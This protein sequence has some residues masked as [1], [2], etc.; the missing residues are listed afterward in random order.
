MTDIRTIAEAISTITAA[1]VDF[2]KAVQLL[3]KFEPHP[4]EA[5]EISY[6]TLAPDVDALGWRIVVLQRGWV[7]VGNVLRIG[8]DIEIRSARVIRRWGTTSGLGELR[9][10]PLEGTTLDEAGTVYAH[11]LGVVLMLDVKAEKWAR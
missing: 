11:E 10:G 6:S 8:S 4:Y 3:E 9:D 1:G 2:D 5:A 7:V